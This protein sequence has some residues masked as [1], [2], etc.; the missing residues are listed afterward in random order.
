MGQEYLTPREIAK[1]LRID[2]TT[3]LRWIRAG[4]L[5]VETNQ[6]GKRNRHRVKKAAIEALETPSPCRL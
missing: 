2:Y 6:E 5:P 4:L 3:V 1:L